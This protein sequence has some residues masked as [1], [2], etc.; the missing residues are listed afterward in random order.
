MALRKEK[1]S[2]KKP[3]EKK[4]KERKPKEKK[5][6]AG[7]KAFSLNS[8]GRKKEASAA[9]GSEVVFGAVTADNVPSFR[10]A[11]ESEGDGFVAGVRSAEPVLSIDEA[12]AGGGWKREIV[13]VAAGA[14]LLVAFMC[15]FCMATDSYEVM[16]F[17]VPGAL[18]FAGLSMLGAIKP[19]K[20]KWIAAGVIAVLLAA[21][22]AVFHSAIGGGLADLINQFYDICEEAQAY[23]YKRVPGGGG[24]PGLGMLWLS[25]LIGLLAALPPARA[26]KGMYYGIT[27]AT[28]F[29]FAYY[30]LIP[31]WICVA[32]LLA[33]LLI[34]LSG[35]N[36][37]SS[38][39]LLLAVMLVFGAIVLIDPGENYSIS[40]MDENFR[41]RFALN[42]LLIQGDETTPDDL[43]GLEDMN[44][45]NTEDGTDDSGS[46]SS[47]AGYA[48]IAIAV[49]IVIAIAA[50]AY[51]LWKRLNKRRMALRAG[52]DSS[53]PREA[54]TAMFPYSVRW[55]RAGG[56]DVG[57]SIFGE[58]T[59]VV[60][61][62]FTQDY[63]DRYRDMYL[64]WR[65][66]AYSDHAVE[67][68]SR[69]DMESFL[70]DT[71]AMVKE[72]LTF[73]ERLGALIKYA[74]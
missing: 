42:S 47:I 16:P 34:A 8:F 36:A 19:G 65:E 46:E 35:S 61:S 43:S 41:D 29:A 70:K 21:S 33:A 31:D 27:M 26:R 39:P 53:D 20:P 68:A 24:K 59:P 74:L 52:I 10:S 48:G 18:V 58:L 60:A 22:M 5:Q 73:K 69:A 49:L 12:A 50:A 67:E 9:E 15:L 54:V 2:E 11:F 7:R 23:V 55:L 44:D 45:P 64:L 40:R 66:A 28:M 13:P 37:L 72:K 1:K 57:A 63:A 56:V 32:V 51:L 3:K 62:E 30:G 71:T 4:P 17:T 6:K 14:L 25:C 38:L